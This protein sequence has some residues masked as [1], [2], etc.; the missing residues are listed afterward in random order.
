MES[1]S[2]TLPDALLFE[3]QEGL[4]PNGAFSAP[5]SKPSFPLQDHAYGRASEKVY[6]AWE[7]G[8]VLGRPSNSDTEDLLQFL[9][10]PNDIYES[11]SPIAS[12]ESDS[13]I[14]DDPHADPPAQSELGPPDVSATI[15]YDVI[16]DMG[17]VEEA[18]GPDPVFS[19]P[20]E[21]WTPPAIL[22]E[23]C[24]MSEVSLGLLENVTRSNVEDIPMP[25]DPFEPLQLQ[26][27]YL[28]EEEK[29]L[30]SEEG[31]L[32]CSDLPLT[33]A[34][35]RILKKVRRKIRNKQSAQDSRRR[36]KEYIDGLE[37]RVAACSVQ[38]QELRKKVRE[39]ETHN[40]SLLGQLQ[41]LQGLIKQTS[42]KAAQTSTCLVI[43]IFSLGL[44]ILPSC[45][46]FL[47][48]T[49]VSR[50]D[51]KPSGVISRHILTKGSLSG[52]DES[53][54]TRSP[55]SPRVQ[56]EEP[57]EDTSDGDPA[58]ARNPDTAREITI[59]NTSDPGSPS[60]VKETNS[61]RPKPEKDPTKQMHADEM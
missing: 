25:Q 5:M 35:E 56:M 49:Q 16:C 6:D 40:M 52:P 30:L 7:A 38:N 58:A 27:L 51:Y 31:V 2:P 43:I 42:T 15:I 50:D 13:G 4:V 21:N 19:N 47:G 54:A 28:T 8:E 37:S 17:M 33:K 36:K 46:S 26:G 10:N 39:L 59:A 41:K 18:T 23:A 55:E 45:S 29:R 11:R 20:L 34:E 22:P 61:R 57:R 12:P 24:A 44:L 9:I 14:S 53:P 1:S 48:G 3:G 60:D 32:L